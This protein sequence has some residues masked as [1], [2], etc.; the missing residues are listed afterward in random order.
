MA[1]RGVNKVILLG[2]VGKDP[3]IRYMQNGD[4]V[5]N[6][7]IAT[8]ES[9]KNKQ[10]EAQ[11]KT[12]WHRV[13]MFGKL[14]GIVEQYVRKGTQLYVEGKLQTR[15]WQDQSGQ[16]R[17]STEIVVDG[18]NGQLQMLGGR[19]T[20]E[21]GTRTTQSSQTSQRAAQGA[22]EASGGGGSQAGNNGFEDDIPFTRYVSLYGE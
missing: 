10:G 20:A 1:S 21:A 9:W 12:E 19:G 11:E 5:A 3:E 4:P 8:S 16:D 15:K 6:L 14:A 2:N 18:F 7:S 17:Y 13:V 22:S